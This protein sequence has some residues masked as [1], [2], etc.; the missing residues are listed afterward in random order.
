MAGKGAGVT[1]FA[2]A[3]A[4]DGRA[5][6]VTGGGQMTGQAAIGGMDLAASSKRRVGGVMAADAIYRGLV[7]HGNR[8]DRNRGAMAMAVTIEVSGMALGAGAAHAAIDPGIPMA[9]D[10]KASATVGRIVTGVAAGMDLGD[11]IAEV[12]VDA[13][14]CCCHRGAMVMDV[15]VEIRGVTSAARFASLNDGRVRPV[16]WAFKC[17]RHGVA[18]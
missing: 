17:R 2:F 8:I 10:T 16:G 6:E 5:G 9:I 7:G 11:P 13:E 1:V 18:V 3:G 14:C 4:V 12:A 15:V